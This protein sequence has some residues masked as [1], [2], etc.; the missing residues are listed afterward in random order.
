MKIKIK[1]IQ[2]LLAIASLALG[3]MACRSGINLDD[4]NQNED[5]AKISFDFDIDKVFPDDLIEKK[6]LKVPERFFLRIFL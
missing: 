5:S 4:E 1:K 6:M 2:T 3:F